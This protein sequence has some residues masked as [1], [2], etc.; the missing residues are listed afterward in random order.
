MK[1]KIWICC[2]AAMIGIP[3][4]G[5]AQL[6]PTAAG[7]AYS[8]LASS[9]LESSID[10]RGVEF[11]PGRPIRGEGL[12]A[13]MKAPVGDSFQLLD[14]GVDFIK[15]GPEIRIEVRGFANE[16]EGSIADRIVLSERRAKLVYDYLLAHGVP[17]HQLV[18]HKGFGSNMPI[19]T[20]ETAEGRQRNSRAELIQLP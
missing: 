15:S 8:L 7:N 4:Q 11:K 5:S 1:G 14:E 3:L 10:L 6:V 16:E 2:W 13:S 19:D 12:A 20:E 18:G 9:V 17:A